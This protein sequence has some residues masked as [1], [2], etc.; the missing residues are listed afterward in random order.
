MEDMTSHVTRRTPIR[1]TSYGLFLQLKDGAAGYAAIVCPSDDDAEVDVVLGCL[2]AESSLDAEYLAITEGIEQIQRSY[3]TDGQCD[4]VAYTDFQTFQKAH[5]EYM[6][7]SHS[8]PRRKT[9]D[10]WTRFMSRH[11]GI[12]LDVRWISRKSGNMH[13]HRCD[14]LS[15]MAARTYARAM[16]YSLD[17]NT[18]IRLSVKVNQLSWKTGLRSRGP[19]AS[20]SDE[21]SSLKVLSP[22]DALGR[23]PQQPLAGLGQR[24]S[25]SCYASGR[26]SGKRRV[27]MPRRRLVQ[28]PL[29]SD[30]SRALYI[31]GAS[32]A[33]CR[34]SNSED[35][36]LGRIAR[37]ALG[38]VYGRENNKF[39]ASGR[40]SSV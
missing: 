26:A 13:H 36:H 14:S 17:G 2:R 40:E 23:K 30:S 35:M 11:P 20:C 24:D 8:V 7:G 12:R 27:I 38:A 33:G 34:C 9:T 4:I 18:S 3:N 22:A 16:R 39:H 1:L 10:L 21:G 31:S 5:R 15:R 32:V 19:L 6:S 25:R 37:P 29:W 28:S